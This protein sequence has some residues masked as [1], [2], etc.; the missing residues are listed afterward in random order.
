MNI[1]SLRV[2]TMSYLN[3]TIKRTIDPLNNALT[4]TEP[5]PYTNIFGQKEMKETKVELFI[6]ETDYS[7]YMVGVGC[8]DSNFWDPKPLINFFVGVRDTKFDSLK[9]LGSITEK[10]KGYVDLNTIVFPY[11][12]PNCQN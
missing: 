11:L 10:I 6:I 3:L 8:I 4:I 12:G 7:N 5:L 1:K 9:I 2:S